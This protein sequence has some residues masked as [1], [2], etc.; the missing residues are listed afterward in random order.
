MSRTSDPPANQNRPLLVPAPLTEL[1]NPGHS[2]VRLSGSHLGLGLK[3]SPPTKGLV[4]G[5]IGYEV[6]PRFLTYCP[7][8]VMCQL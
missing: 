4:E 6:N 8:R 1:K 3:S 7:I 2:S 5:G